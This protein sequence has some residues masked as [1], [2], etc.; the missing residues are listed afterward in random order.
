MNNLL[1]H[2]YSVIIFYN[3]RDV[4]DVIKNGKTLAKEG[5]RITKKSITSGKCT[6]LHSLVEM[7]FASPLAVCIR[8]RSSSFIGD[9]FLSKNILI[10]V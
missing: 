8:L 4:A 10:F 1:L 7:V 2:C 9:M 3:K 6:R 5:I